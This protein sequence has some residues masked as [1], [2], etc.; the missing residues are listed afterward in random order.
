MGGGSFGAAAV[1][2]TSAAVVARA[3]IA[4]TSASKLSR[5][6]KFTMMRSMSLLAPKVYGKSKAGA[7]RMAL[8]CRWNVAA[9]VDARHFDCAGINSRVAGGL[10]DHGLASKGAFLVCA[11]TD[12][13]ATTWRYGLGRS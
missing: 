5:V 2:T 9:G 8:L 11:N 6:G 13:G 10:S 4:A 1:P 12:D 7:L 3:V